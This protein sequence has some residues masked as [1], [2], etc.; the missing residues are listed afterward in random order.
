MADLKIQSN[1]K[2]VIIDES[3]GFLFFGAVSYFAINPYVL[4]FNVLL[5]ALVLSLVVGSMLLYRFWYRSTVRWIITDEQIVFIRGI[6]TRE[7]DYIELYRVNDFNEVQSF[8]QRIF[9]LKSIYICSSDKSHP[10]LRMS[11]IGSNIE[12]LDVVRKRVEL[13]KKEKKIYEMANY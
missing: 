6:F 13:N 10:L 7:K 8:V 11:G 12:V 5:Y 3:F 2:Q 9:G 4:G 1:L